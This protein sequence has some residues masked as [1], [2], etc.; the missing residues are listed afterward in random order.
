MKSK[1]MTGTTGKVTIR[2]TVTDRQGFALPV[3]S[4]DAIGHPSSFPFLIYGFPTVE[5]PFVRFQ[6]D[7]F[8][9]RFQ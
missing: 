5:I 6:E 3:S 7:P 4:M 2:M 8:I 9:C 1:N